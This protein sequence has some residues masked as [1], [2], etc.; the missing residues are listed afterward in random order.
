MGGTT[1]GVRPLARSGPLHRGARHASPML[2]PRFPLGAFSVR[3]P[4]RRSKRKKISPSCTVIA[5]TPAARLA[6]RKTAPPSG[7]PAGAIACAT[8]AALMFIDLRDHYGA[9][10][11]RRRPGF[12]GLRA[13]GESC[14]P[15]ASCAS[16]GDVRKRPGRHGKPEMPTGLIEVYV[17]RDRSAGAG[18]RSAVPVFGDQ[19]YPED[20]RLRYR[21]LDLRRETLHQNIMLRGRM[22]D[23]IRRRMKEQGF[24]E[25]QT[26]ILTASSPE[27]RARLPGAV[28][29][30]SG[31]VLRAAAGAAA[32]QA[33]R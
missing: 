3:R 30:A 17:T 26:P 32:V 10:A 2:T 8:T 15:K 28:A 16:T 13:S 21:F 4:K 18:G 19:P 25:F 11:M 33:A 27:G 20:M 14:V 5:P 29:P 24:F 7:S 22:I 12:A 1:Y 23:S 6:S 31:Q 9:D